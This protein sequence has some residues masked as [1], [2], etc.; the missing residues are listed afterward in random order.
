MCTRVYLELRIEAMRRKKSGGSV[1]RCGESCLLS[2]VPREVHFLICLVGLSSWVPDLFQNP[3]RVSISFIDAAH[4][5]ITAAAE[6]GSSQ[7]RRMN[8]HTTEVQ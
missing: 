3:L 2:K 4:I 8:V 6:L 5:S 1:Q 7:V